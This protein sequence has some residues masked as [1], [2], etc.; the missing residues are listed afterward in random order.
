MSQRIK[1]GFW[2]S[3]SLSFLWVQLLVGDRT[4]VNFLRGQSSAFRVKNVVHKLKR[5]EKKQKRWWEI[6]T[7]KSV[8]YLQVLLTF[9]WFLSILKS[10]RLHC[11]YLLSQAIVDNTILQRCFL[12]FLMLS[13]CFCLLSL[14]FFCRTWVILREFFM[15]VEK[16]CSRVDITDLFHIWNGLSF[17]NLKE[18]SLLLWQHLLWTKLSQVFLH[19]LKDKK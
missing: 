15:L 4:C 19:P 1:Q 6:K 3:K 5:R 16:L 14:S 11:H 8:W 10:T 2:A 17:F 12:Y 9:W 7:F 18:Q 13:N